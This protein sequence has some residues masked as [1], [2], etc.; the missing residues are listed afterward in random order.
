MEIRITM[1]F[2]KEGGFNAFCPI[3]TA[4]M[5][6]VGNS[7]G[8]IQSETPCGKRETS[9]L[10]PAF[11]ICPIAQYLVY[12]LLTSC[13]CRRHSPAESSMAPGHRRSNETASGR[14]TGF[15]GDSQ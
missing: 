9:E 10:L 12:A 5:M 11:A 6:P 3:Y 4:R 15:S 8:S 14:N 1:H 7:M 13:R 2:G